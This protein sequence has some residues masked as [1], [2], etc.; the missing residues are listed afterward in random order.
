MAWYAIRHVLHY[1]VKPDGKNIFE[2]RVVCIEASSIGEAHAKAAK[3]VEEYARPN[4]SKVY[5][6]SIAY[7]LDEDK[8]IDG[9]EVWSELYE[10]EESLEEYYVGRYI[11]YRYKPM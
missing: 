10:S 9:Y 4:N 3:E 6:E 8:L 1:G 2:E 11:I 5:P 7:E